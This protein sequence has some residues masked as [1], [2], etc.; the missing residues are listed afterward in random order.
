MSAQA[1]GVG[2]DALFGANRL[3][4]IL[5]GLPPHD[6]VDA[7]VSAWDAGIEIVEVPIGEASQIPALEATVRVGSQRG[8]AVGAGTVIS[9]DHVARAAQAGASYTV[10]PGFDAE[11]LKAS[12]DAGMAHLPGVATASE[13]QRATGAGCV[14]LKAFPAAV[15][16]P[17]W[18]QAV[19]GPFP[20]AKFVAAGGLTVNNVGDFWDAGVQV[21]AFGSVL[22]EP[23]SAPKLRGLAGEL[24]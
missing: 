15:L 14:W 17:A 22:K 1:G 13:V 2:F 8:R 24:S 7:A 5:R 6:T 23:D 4:A 20:H 3:M 12:V 21:A 9:R 18:F 11:V 10:A 19:K 16:G